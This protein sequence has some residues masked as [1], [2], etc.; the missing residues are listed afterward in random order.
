MLVDAMLAVG[1]STVVAVPL[2]IFLHICFGN[3][4]SKDES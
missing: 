4:N 3:W 1:M 2:G